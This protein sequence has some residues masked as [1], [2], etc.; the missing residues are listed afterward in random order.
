[1]RY[2]QDV[3]D[4][5]QKSSLLSVELSFFLGEVLVPAPALQGI[6]SVLASL[7]YLSHKHQQL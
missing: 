4:Q 7:S 2:L 1:M 6:L 3:N 5:Q